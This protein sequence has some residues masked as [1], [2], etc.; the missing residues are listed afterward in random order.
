M[1]GLGAD[2]VIGSTATD[3]AEAVCDVDVVLGTLGGRHRAALARGAPPGRPPGHRRRRRRYRTD[4]RR[5]GGRAVQRHRGRPDPFGL[6]GL[7]EL[8]ERGQLRVH[9]RTT[10]PVERVAD[11]HRL[12][13]AGHLRGKLVLTV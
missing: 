7:V 2:E 10:F 11:A 1:E 6:R 12:L 3:F 13:G 8:V 9:V 5:G 4:R